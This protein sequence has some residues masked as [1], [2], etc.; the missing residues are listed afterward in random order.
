VRLLLLGM[1]LAALALLPIA[2]QADGGGGAESAVAG[3]GRLWSSTRT[4]VIGVDPASGRVQAIANT[5]LHGRLIGADSRTVWLVAPHRLVAV[6]LRTHRVRKRVWLRQP[7]YS[8]TVGG[9]ALW[10]PSFSFASLTKF[11]STTG[12]RLWVRPVAA[13]P[14]AVTVADRSVWVASTGSWHKGKGGVMVPDGGGIV[15]R[16]DPLR[17]SVLA[18]VRVDR[19]PG[20][21]AAA[22]NSLWVLNGRGADVSDTLNRIDLRT[23]KVVASIKVPHWASDVACGTRYCWIV[24]EPKSAGGVVTRIDPRSNKT[25]SRSIPNS[26][27]PAAV[28]VVEGYVWVADPGRAALIRIDPQTLRVSKRVNIPVS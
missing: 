5:Q 2:A 22:R 11:D 7:T 26:W 28:V 25:V 14:E 27:V 10:L 4:G 20:A 18:R 17:G 13:A 1:V 6:D 23:N 21:L 15:T 19:G 3:A 8:D 9:G 12:R 16:L 24:S